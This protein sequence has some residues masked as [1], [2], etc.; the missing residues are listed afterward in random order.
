MTYR[1]KLASTHYLGR[2]LV[3]HRVSEMREFTGF[4]QLSGSKAQYRLLFVAEPFGQ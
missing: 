4:V 3:A 2:R 1:L